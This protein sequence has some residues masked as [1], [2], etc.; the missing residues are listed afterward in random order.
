M[1]QKKRNEGEE[2]KSVDKH[3][4]ERFLQRH[5]EIVFAKPKALPIGRAAHSCRKVLIPFFD[6]YESYLNEEKPI[7][8]L[9]FN[10]D[11]TSTFFH[12]RKNDQVASSSS[13]PS[14]IT[15][16]TSLP[17]ATSIVFMCSADGCRYLTPIVIPYK[18]LPDEYKLATTSQEVFFP[19]TTGHVTSSLFF[20]LFRIC[21]LPEI[22]KKRIAIGEKYRHA[23]L[24]MDGCVGH[25]TEEMKR[26]CKDNLVDLIKLPSHTSHIIQPNDQFIFA[27]MKRVFARETESGQTTTASQKREVFT[28]ILRDGLAAASYPSTII[29]SWKVTGLWPLDKSVVLKH[30]PENPPS[31]AENSV[32]P[33]KAPEGSN[34]GAI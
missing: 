32:E 11:E 19:S 13:S 33:T 9:L 29:S 25:F 7:P 28:T 34:F 18:T 31:C 1:L 26:L 24:I 2:C 14:V 22:I 17:T 8:Q 5:P 20:E 27:N 30:L 12:K 6:L 16:E 23:A 10:I 21:F 15:P 3:W 4:T